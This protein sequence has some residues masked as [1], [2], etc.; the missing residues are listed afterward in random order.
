VG[1]DYTASITDTR[2]VLESALA[3]VD[4]MELDPAPAVVLIGLGA[5]SVDWSVRVWAARENFG[6]VRESLIRSIKESLDDAGI[7]IPFP[8]MDV[9]LDGQIESR[10]PS[11]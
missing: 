9:H 1:V 7:G 10:L 5:S 3:R 8:Q 4:A 2:V 6:T 11:V